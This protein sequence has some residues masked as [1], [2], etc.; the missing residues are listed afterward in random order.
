LPLATQFVQWL[1]LR[2]DSHR[3]LI[4]MVAQGLRDSLIDR[5]IPPVD[6][7]AAGESP[8]LLF[9]SVSGG[10]L[11]K[12][13]QL[14][15]LKVPQPRGAT[16]RYRASWRPIS[17]RLLG[18]IKIEAHLNHISVIRCPGEKPA[19]SRPITTSEDMENHIVEGWID[20]VSVALPI[21]G[22]RVDLDGP[23]KPLL[24]DIDS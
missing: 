18:G 22:F 24:P 5:L 14:F 17:Q 8:G 15:R 23:L 3:K 7:G 21:L 2:E 16:A 6:L 20:G 9:Q 10:G 11:D 19:R 1:P 13:V 12:R 4:G